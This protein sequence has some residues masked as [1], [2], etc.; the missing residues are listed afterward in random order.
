[1][2]HLPDPAERADHRLN[3]RSHAA[4]P[5]ALVVGLGRRWHLTATCD[6][7]ATMSNDWARP[8][9]NFEIVAKDPAAQAAFYRQ[10]FNWEIPD[11]P[12]AQIPPGIGGPEAGIGGHIRAGDSP[13]VSIY[14]QVREIRA[15][16]ERVKELGGE[17]VLEP[18]DIPNGPTLAAVTDPEG[19]PLTLV[20]Q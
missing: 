9:V 12:L 10:L 2:V 5:A 11:G 7:I 14:V 20:Q 1:M 15:S 13:G 18:F 19:N 8:M 17:V 6:R 3:V 4:I 16:L